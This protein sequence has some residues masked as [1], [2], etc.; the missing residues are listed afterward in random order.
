MINSRDADTYYNGL[1]MIML[2]HFSEDGRKISFRYYSP[3][4]NA[5]YKTVNRFEI[6]LDD[7]YAQNADGSRITAL[8]DGVKTIKTGIT[9]H[10]LIA[11]SYDKNGY[12]LDVQ[13][14]DSDE[15]KI[16]IAQ[17]AAV[18]KGFLWNEQ[19]LKPAGRNVTYTR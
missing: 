18:L 11:A 3:V 1:G 7:L 12:L 2:M 8:T 9:G 13:V 17:N 15:V 5:Y 4:H 14:S 19:G 16:D 10:K 6:T